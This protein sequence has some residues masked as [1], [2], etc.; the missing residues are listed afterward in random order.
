MVNI[1]NKLIDKVKGYSLVLNEIE[2]ERKYNEMYNFVKT[3]NVKTI[4]KILLDKNEDNYIICKNEH[5][6]LYNDNIVHEYICTDYTIIRN[7]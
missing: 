7:D 6:K 4:K 1:T 2:Y 3:N 5:L